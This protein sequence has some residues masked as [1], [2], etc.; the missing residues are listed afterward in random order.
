MP[1]AASSTAQDDWTEGTG[2][3]VGPTATQFQRELSQAK[4]PAQIPRPA[5][6][7]AT[8]QNQQLSAK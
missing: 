3:P 1:K 4:R 2:P 8:T 6:T 7:S 5:G